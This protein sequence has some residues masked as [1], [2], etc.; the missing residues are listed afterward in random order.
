MR[1]VTPAHHWNAIVLSTLWNQCLEPLTD[2]VC[3][4]CTFC[5]EDIENEKQFLG[6]ESF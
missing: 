6:G 3:A 2:V 5:V 1:R 4:A